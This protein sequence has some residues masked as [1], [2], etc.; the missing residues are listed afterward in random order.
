MTL[1]IVLKAR[2]GGMIDARGAAITCAEIARRWLD[3]GELTLTGAD[4]AARLLARRTVRSI[5]SGPKTS[6]ASKPI[7]RSRM[8]RNRRCAISAPIIC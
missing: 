2:G 5:W 4:L 8:R 1:N 6:T 3:A 7:C